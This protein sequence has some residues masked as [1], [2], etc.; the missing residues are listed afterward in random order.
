MWDFTIDP[1]QRLPSKAPRPRSPSAEGYA[2]LPVCMPGRPW[3]PG[4]GSEAGPTLAAL[5]Y[6]RRA[7]SA[8]SGARL[9]PW[10]E[11]C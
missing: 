2:D 8:P 10:R 5:I 3:Q 11:R 1:R 9:A 4:L 6:S 7:D